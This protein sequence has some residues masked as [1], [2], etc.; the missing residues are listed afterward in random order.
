MFSFCFLPFIGTRTVIAQVGANPE[1]S[2]A[3]LVS[4]AML[5]LSPSLNP[6]LYLWRMSDIRI[7][8]LQLFRTN[9]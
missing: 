9:S 3:Y 2:A 7:G 8:V 6:G 5:F 1:T 4:L